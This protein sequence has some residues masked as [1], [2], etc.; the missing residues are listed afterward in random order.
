[1]K[2]VT[3]SLLI[4]ALTAPALAMAAEPQTRQGFGIS[5]GLGGGTGELDCD[6]CGTGSEDGFSGYLRLGG[7]VRPDLFV[8]FESNG[9]SAS[10]DGVDTTGGF[11][12]VAL[13]W[14]PNEEKGFYVKGN[15]GLA[16]VIIEDDEDEVTSGHL[17]LGLGV[18]YDWRLGRNFSLT[19][20]INLVF[21][22]KN[23]LKFNDEGT[24]IKGSFSLV[25]L[26]LGFTWH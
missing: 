9:F 26:G 12:S 23:E 16:G 6:A 22:G 3:R 10:S 25:Q 19:P 17:G 20:Y 2:M 1:M 14:Y 11:Y 15:L 4:L 7:Y 21:T 8:A 24:G 13:Q 18:G 5:F